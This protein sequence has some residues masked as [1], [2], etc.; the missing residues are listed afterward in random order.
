[1]WAT[2]FLVCMLHPGTIVQVV[3][4][5]IK[6]AFWPAYGNHAVEGVESQIAQAAS[7]AEALRPGSMARQKDRIT[8]I[9]AESE[10][11]TAI[12]KGQ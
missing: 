8:V 2:G 3:K 12:A 11:P 5:D 6:H 1:M 7:E 4:H 10:S 9:H